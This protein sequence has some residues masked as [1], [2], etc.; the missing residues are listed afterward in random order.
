MLRTQE[1]RRTINEFSS[2]ND[3]VDEIK[4]PD[5]LVKW[6]QGGYFTERKEFERLRGKLLFE[7][8]TTPGRVLTIRQLDFTEQQYVVYHSSTLYRVESDLS[9]LNSSIT[10]TVPLNPFIY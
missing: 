5:D 7:N 4:M 3:L 6:A 8:A 10:S 1:L 9:A 2:I